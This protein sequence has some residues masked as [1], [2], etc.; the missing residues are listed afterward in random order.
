MLE[1]FGVH[2]TTERV[3]RAMLDNPTTDVSQLAKTL[4]MKRGEVAA[5]LDRLAALRLV[6]TDEGGVN[7]VSPVAPDQAIESLLAQQERRLA[8]MQELVD[9]S[10]QNVAHYVEAFVDSRVRRD[11]HD[12]VEIIDEAEVVRSRL[13]QLVREARVSAVTI[14]GGAPLPSDAIESSRRLD[15]ELLERKVVLR[16]IVATPSLTSEAWRTHLVEASSIGMQVRVHPSP[17]PHT[18][19]IDGSVALI[20]RT[21]RPGALILHGPDLVAP[22]AQLFT[23]VW[24]A[25][26]PWD[27]ILTQGAE[28]E[29]SEARLRQVVSLLAQGLKDDAIARKTATSVRTVRRLVAAATAA[30]QAESRFQ[31]GVEALRRGWVD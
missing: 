13:Y 1:I 2:G 21:S 30:L 26:Q 25:A 12:L 10:R 3:Y 8:Q 24:N 18:I 6:T 15:R 7:V 27:D 9:T 20:P 4:K 23:Q 28:G 17:G 11:D 5:E 22:V 29:F 31:A 16:A 14:H 19:V